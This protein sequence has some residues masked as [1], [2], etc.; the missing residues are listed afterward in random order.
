MRERGLRTLRQASNRRCTAASRVGRSRLALVS[1]GCPPRDCDATAYDTTPL[2]TIHARLPKGHDFLT[3]SPYSGT[4]YDL[5]IKPWKELL[6][7]VPVYG[8]ADSAGSAA[9]NRLAAK[10]FRSA[11]AD[12]VYLFNFFCPREWYVEPPFEVLKDLGE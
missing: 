5:P 4:Q 3:V 6:G 1:I 11:G 12:G 10:Q 2:D 7:N 9:N 8:C